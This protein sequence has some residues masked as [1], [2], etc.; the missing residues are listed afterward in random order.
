MAYWNSG[1]IWNRKGN[2]N[3]FTWNSKYFLYFVRLNDAIK[4]IDGLSE[5]LARLVLAEK[6]IQFYDTIANSALYARLE[7]FSMEDDAAVSLLFSLAEEIGIK[8]ELTDYI[9]SLA[10]SDNISML[11]EIRQLASLLTDEDFF[12]DEKIF[13]RAFHYLMD[14]FS[15]SELAT[16]FTTIRIFDKFSLKDHD[17]PRTAESDWL[18]GVEGGLDR[19][20]DYFIPLYINANES[21]IR[22]ED[23]KIGM[24]VSWK[25]SELVVMPE[26]DMVSIE[27]PGVDG[28]LHQGS[29]YK[30]RLFSLALFSD[31]GLTISQKEDLKRR[32]TQVL[33]TSKK[34]SRKLTIQSR[35]I[36]FDARYQ[37]STIKDGPSFVRCDLDVVVPPYA[38]D[39]F[40]NELRTS[41]LIDNTEGLSPLSPKFT[42]EGGISNP[43]FQ[44]GPYT[45]RYNGT[46]PSGKRLIADFEQYSVYIEDNFQNKTNALKDWAGDFHSIPAGSSEALVINRNLE[47]RFLAE[48]SVSVLW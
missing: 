17:K 4:V 22:E 24:R 36:T 14:K 9:V 34:Q 15:A 19:A 45:Y 46:I 25:D 20:Y 5:T 26:N 7:T 3:G 2:Q 44:L 21:N 6:Q 32:I 39:M 29:T 43:Y 27:I 28:V 10:L 23:R 16:Y 8:D 40:P 18:I 42:I 41:G 33:D 37:S 38:R 1:A 35:G 30:E 11:Q 47:G 48:W 31:D 13:S 12:L